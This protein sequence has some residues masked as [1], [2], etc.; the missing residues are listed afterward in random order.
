MPNRNALFIVEG[1]SDEPIFIRRLF[2]KCYAKQEYKTYVY[3]T[4]LHI[5]AKRL[6]EDYPD[7][8]EDEIDIRLVLRSYEESN[9][10]RDVLSANY[11]DIYLIFDFEPQH[12][13]PHFKTI[14]RMLNYFYDSSFRGKLF[15][16]YPMMQSYRHF[17]RLPEPLFYDVKATSDEWKRYKRIVGEV[18]AYKDISKYDYRIFVSLAVHHLKKANY[19]FNGIYELPSIDEYLLWNLKDIFEKQV[20]YKDRD[21]FVYVLNTCIFIL[22]DYQPDS[23]F[24]QI[25]NQGRQFL[26]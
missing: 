24:R 23:F 20:I 14:G 8:D 9:N 11:T 12:D 2:E 7:F 6:E 4:N 3:K 10:Q 13:S 1:N 26:I 17:S 19:I 5:L 16:N 21:S 22:I 18:S 25:K 15:I